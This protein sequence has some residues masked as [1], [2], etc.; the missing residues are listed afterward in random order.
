MHTIDI[1]SRRQLAM[2]PERSKCSKKRR[3]SPQLNGLPGSSWCFSWL[4]KKRD[5]SLRARAVQTRGK[6]LWKSVHNKVDTFLAFLKSVSWNVSEIFCKNTLCFCLDAWYPP[7]SLHFSGQEHNWD[8]LQWLVWCQRRNQEAS[9]GRKDVNRVWW[10]WTQP[11]SQRVKVYLPIL[12]FTSWMAKLTNT[13][14]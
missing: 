11:G 2:G 5:K 9:E 8:D 12:P 3:N 7:P 1:K 4:L 6:C 10:A 13:V 14:Q